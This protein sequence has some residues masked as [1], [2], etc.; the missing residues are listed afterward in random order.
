M[1]IYNHNPHNYLN[2]EKYFRE[3]SGENQNTYFIYP[4]NFSKCLNLMSLCEANVRVRQTTDGNARGWMHIARFISKV[5]DTY[6]HNYQER[7]FTQQVRLRECYSILLYTNISCLLTDI[8]KARILA[9]Y[10]ILTIL[11]QMPHNGDLKLKYIFPL[12]INM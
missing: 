11:I 12:Y 3:S 8:S 7:C 10:N 1:Y 5:T 9:E 4:T 6:T 2:N